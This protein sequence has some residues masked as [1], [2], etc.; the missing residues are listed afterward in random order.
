MVYLG[1]FAQRFW[2][3]VCSEVYC[4]LDAEFSWKRLNLH[5][6]FI[7][8]KMEKGDSQYASMTTLLF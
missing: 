8:F 5:L 1:F 6:N 3:L 4:N 7:N 2:N